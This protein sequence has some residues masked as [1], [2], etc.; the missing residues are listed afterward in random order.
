M[1]IRNGIWPVQWAIVDFDIC[2]FSGQ[3]N[4]RKFYGA[5]GNHGKRGKSQFHVAVTNVA[6]DINSVGQVLV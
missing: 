6:T 2:G 1:I 4:G 5:I 3:S